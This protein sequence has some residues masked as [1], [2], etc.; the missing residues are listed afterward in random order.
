MSCLFATGRLGIRTCLVPSKQVITRKQD[1]SCPLATGSHMCLLAFWSAYAISWISI[2]EDR[3]VVFTF[4]LWKH[5]YSQ[6][7][8]R[9]TLSLSVHH[10]KLPSNH[11]VL[12]MNH[13][14]VI[15]SGDRSGPPRTCNLYELKTL[16]IPPEEGPSGWSLKKT[17]ALKVKRKGNSVKGRL[18]CWDTNIL[19]IEPQ[20]TW[21]L[22]TGC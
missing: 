19:N 21:M 17:G 22:G 7:S 2:Y 1:V 10:L 11:W 15:L 9:K 5:I 8:F 14:L 3:D 13:A 4:L 6:D 20:S 18:Y 12:N 16:S